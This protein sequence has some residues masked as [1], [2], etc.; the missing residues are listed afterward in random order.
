MDFKQLY[1]QIIVVQR[2]SN[3]GQTE[4]TVA[5]PLNPGLTKSN[6]RVPPTTWNIFQNTCSKRLKAAFWM[7]WESVTSKALIVQYNT[8]LCSKACFRVY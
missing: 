7:S 1:C 5:V 8:Y 6:V 4:L 3:E 2:H